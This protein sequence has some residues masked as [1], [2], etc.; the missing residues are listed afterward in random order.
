MKARIGQTD[1]TTALIAKDGRYLLPLK[2]RVRSAEKLKEGDTIV[3]PL[4]VDGV[5]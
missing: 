5:D 3:A 1:F 2:D 4:E